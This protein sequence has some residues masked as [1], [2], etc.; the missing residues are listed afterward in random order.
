M[1]IEARSHGLWQ[2]TAPP[3]PATGPLG[4]EV[5]ADVAVIGA[6]F[7]GL[8][9]A[10]HLAEGGARVAVLEA[11]EIGFGGSG[12]NVGLVNA[13][14][15]VMP[16]DLPKVLG[17]EHGERL[18]RLLGEAPALVF[19]LIERYGIA[20]EAQ[21]AGTLHCAVGPKGL[22]EI[23]ARAAQWAARGAPVRLIGATDAAARTGSNAYAGALL[24]ERAGTIQPLA[25]V[26][27][28]ARAAIDAGA[29]VFTRSP[30]SAARQATGGAWRLEAPEGAV[31]APW[32]VVATNAYG[33]GSPFPQ[34][35]AELVPLPYFQVATRPLGHN[36]R[37]TILPGREGAW[38]TKEVLSSFRLDAAGRLLFGSVGALRGTGEPVHRAW[39]RRAIRRLFPQLGEVAFET[40]WY[41]RIGMTSDN[42]PRFHELAPKVI[43]FSGYNGRGIAPGTIFGRILA[44][45]ILGQGD[46][47]DLPLPVTAP[48]TVRFR[49]L[50]GAYYEYGAQAAHLAEGRMRGLSGEPKRAR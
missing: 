22:A 31:T 43:G 27:G 25:Y 21:R 16:D 28:L 24:D 42:V 6:G 40:A 44:R 29:L 13:G 8:S 20:C 11:A 7:T 49:S 26:R 50:K 35:A 10:L 19:D 30:V 38:D 47:T 45:H 1:T 34:V 36:L 39:A 4:G 48:E 18:L 5:T 33:A 23:T 37:A 17:A 2:L 46:R 15:W 32:V 12:R 9:A 41:G 14:L 3:P